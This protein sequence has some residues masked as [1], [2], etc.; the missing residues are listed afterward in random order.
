M[1]GGVLG[2]LE[3]GRGACRDGGLI[4]AVVEVCRGERVCFGV[5]RDRKSVE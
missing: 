3:R 5:A 4:T 2:W 1:I